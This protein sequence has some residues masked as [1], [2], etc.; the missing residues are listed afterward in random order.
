M[1]QTAAA[2]HQETDRLAAT[3]RGFVHLNLFACICL[4]RFGVI[5]GGSEIYLC[6]LVFMASG[7]WLL[8]TGAARIRPGVLFAFGLAAASFVVSTL[9]AVI[10]PR[11]GV[12][13]SITSLFGVL[14]FN[15][16][17]MFGPRR[18]LAAEEVF[19]IFLFYIR[20]ACVL[21]IIQ[22]GLQFVGI[23]LFTLGNIIP[24]LK[25]ILVEANYNTEGVIAWGSTIQ[26]ANGVFPLEPG[27]FSQLIAIA[28]LLDGLVLKRFWF[29]PLYAAAYI[30]SSSGTGLLCLAVTLAA[31]PILAPRQSKYVI[32]AV[33]T[34]V[35][36]AIGLY[37]LF[38]AQIGHLL[39]R[40]SEFNTP[41]TS[42]YM[43]YVAQAKAWSFF[44]EGWRSAIGSGPGAYERFPDYVIGS[45]SAAVKVFAEY[46]L[47][48]ISLFGVFLVSAVWNKHVPLISVM[49]LVIYQFGGGNLLQA[50]TLIL[51]ALLCV[52]SN[53]PVLVRDLAR[54]AP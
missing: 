23:R 8:H 13:M 5:S 32:A 24:A 53:G 25:P 16:V 28:V 52:W 39:G 22:Y 10:A 12:G 15:S 54:S 47:I 38:P 26:R 46:G 41:G 17:F 43:R 40:A 27:G 31:A 33:V 35:P 45:G 18:Q 48:G 37:F 14:V 36:L 49:M 42:G 21:G 1:D 6:F 30:L 29:M 4:Q 2:P 7:A 9:V 34:G 20:I 51:M 44:S 19:K 50:P 11:A 3:E